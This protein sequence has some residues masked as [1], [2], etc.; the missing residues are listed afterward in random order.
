[1]ELGGKGRK[2]LEVGSEEANGD[3]PV[4]RGKEMNGVTFVLRV[5]REE[6]L[7]GSPGKILM[8]YS[9]AFRVWPGRGLH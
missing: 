2:P 8:E 9:V 7:G 3:E 4:D 6:I 5:L 1:M